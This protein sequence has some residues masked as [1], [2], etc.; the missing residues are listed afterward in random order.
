MDRMIDD[1]HPA[2]PAEK[3]FDLAALG[4]G[5]IE[6]APG[7]Y[8]GMPED[9]YHQSFALS[10]S[11]TKLIR[12]S[13]LDWWARSILNP[14]L[15]DVLEDEVDSAAQ[16]YGRAL[17]VRVLEGA[18][19][20]AARYV[21]PP[22][23]ADYPNALDTVADMRKVIDGL[24]EGR[25]KADR[26]KKSGSKDDLIDAILTAAPQ[27]QIWEAVVEK[28]AHDHA[29]KEFVKPQLIDQIEMA[30]AMILRDPNLKDIFTKGYPEVSIFYRCQH[31]G[32]PCKAR[33]DYLRSDELID[34][35]SFADTQLRPIDEAVNREMNARGY[36]RQAAWYLE[37]A[38]YIP[39]MIRAG[40]VYGEPEPGF[41][42]A[43]LKH[44]HKKFRFVFSRKGPAPLARARWFSQELGAYEIAKTKNDT[45]KY[46]FQQC[47][48]TYGAEPWVE[49]QPTQDFT[50]DNFA[51]WSF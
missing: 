30:A 49:S 51:D 16:Q 10:A 1:V 5:P 38:S 28:Y 27:T 35:K 47:L 12:S 18:A 42:D 31:T 48:S 39:A 6:T 46:V 40:R 32:I 20:F 29:G 9:E 7:L 19:A 50:D 14:R 36:A 37:A 24:N 17:H 43:L 26:I 44:K 11:G 3:P 22:N 2:A 45:A 23:K 25:A 13:A 8:F 21:P 4:L 41:L 34:L 15:A 33:F